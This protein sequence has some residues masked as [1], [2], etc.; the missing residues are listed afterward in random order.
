LHTLVSLSPLSYLIVTQ[1]RHAHLLHLVLVQP[2]LSLFSFFFSTIPPPPSS[3]LFPYT[4]LFRSKERQAGTWTV[5][6]EE[7]DI[8]PLCAARSEE[9]TSELQSLTNLVCRLLLEKKKKLQHR[10]HLG[11]NITDDFDTTH[12][13]DTCTCN[14]TLAQPS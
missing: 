2:S 12:C 9:H 7:R 8:P 5:G 1:L 11:I 4:T 3:P 6:R 13:R 10:R 14:R